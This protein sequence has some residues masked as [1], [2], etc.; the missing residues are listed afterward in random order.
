MYKVE[1]TL[2]SWARIVGRLCTIRLMFRNATYCISGSAESNV[3]RG[4]AISTGDK[5]HLLE[6]H[7]Q[8]KNGKGKDDG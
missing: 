4:G 5:F 6:D 1:F 2:I 3:T 8:G 7:L